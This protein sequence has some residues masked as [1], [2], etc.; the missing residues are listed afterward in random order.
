MEKVLVINQMIWQ[1]NCNFVVTNKLPYLLENLPVSEVLSYFNRTKIF[2]PETS[3]NVLANILCF[4]SV[5]WNT[6][7]LRTGAFFFFAWPQISTTIII[8]IVI[9]LWDKFPERHGENKNRIFPVNVP[10]CSYK[11]NL[12]YRLRLVRSVN[13]CN[14]LSSVKS[15]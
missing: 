8:I 13:R 15:Q 3:P 10:S 1:W 14:I 5:G 12:V 11:P 6:F 2:S 9:I 4:C 7:F